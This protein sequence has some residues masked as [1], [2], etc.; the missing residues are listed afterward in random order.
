MSKKD[1][2]VTF[3][4]SV[5]LITI[6][7]VLVIIA[8]GLSTVFVS[9]F[10]SDDARRTAEENNHTVNSRTADAVDSRIQ[11]IES[12]VLLFLD[13]AFDSKNNIEAAFEKRFFERNQNIIA[14][15]C[16]NGKDR[17]KTLINPDLLNDIEGK[18][19]NIYSSFSS[20]IN[21]ILQTA[22][23]ND[24][25]FNES[26]NFKV[27][28][29][30]MLFPFSSLQGKQ[31]VGILLSVE[32]LNSNFG[33]GS[34]NSS[35]MINRDGDILLDGDISQITENKS[36]KDTSLFAAVKKY[37]DTNRQMLYKDK[38]G[39]Q[40]FGAYTKLSTGGLTV[41]TTINAALVYEVARNTLFRNI[42]LSAAVLFLSI[43]MI[44]FWSKSIS[45]PLKKLAS[46][47]HRIEAGEYNVELSRKRHDEIR[48]LTNSFV[49]MEHGLAERERLKDTFGRFIN[50]EIAKKAMKGD[51]TLGGEIKNVTV[52]FSDIRS[53]T[54]MSEK[55]PAEEIVEF[56]NT[57][58][59]KMVH[60]VDATGG[61][62][63]KFIGDA[64]MAVWG[65]PVSAGSAKKDAFNSIKT[66]IMMRKALY[67]LNKTRQ[68]QGKSAIHIG[69]GIN[70]G[71]VVAGQ[72]GSSQRMEY[73]VIGDTV[74]IASRTESLNKPFY[75]DILI[76][77]NTYN[78]IKDY[79]IAEEMP[80][81]HVKGKTEAMKMYA[82]I[83]F[84]NTNQVDN[85]KTHFRTIKEVRTFLEL[86]DPDFINLDPDAEEKKYEIDRQR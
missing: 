48:I 10:V 53:F 35:Y 31:T 12:N 45:S 6:F 55:M 82:V 71:E 49:S 75:T 68:E 37:N 33:M 52:F 15:A 16:F 83:D 78:M 23:G 64:I 2:T 11:T 80:S 66:A 86:P 56:L 19:N 47:A 21:D 7:S 61:I 17:V 46:A 36:V 34:M 26:S 14:V 58:M 8:L 72:I 62:V 25:F 57:Y 60:C 76:T 29:M 42:Y 13:I 27:P 32:S 70:S 40:F 50:P 69:C 51:L 67:F 84:K 41:I 79:I 18:E 24:S 73:T 77:A 1:Q 44:W 63:D 43:L 39:N 54:A 74:N 81:V 22:K 3:S 65:A 9:Y 38:D 59:T 85:K 30:L 28:V 20:H 5:Q 4:I